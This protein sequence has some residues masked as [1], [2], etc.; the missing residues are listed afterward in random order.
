[1]K[2]YR[3]P[4][5]FTRQIAVKK[6]L[7][8]YAARNEREGRIGSFEYDLKKI[9]R[10]IREQLV[11]EN[12]S[13]PDAKIDARV[14]KCMSTGWE[15]VKER[16]AERK[17]AHDTRKSSGLP[18]TATRIGALEC[19][20]GRVSRFERE[21]LIY[22]VAEFTPEWGREYVHAAFTGDTEAASSG[23]TL[24]LV[25]HSSLHPVLQR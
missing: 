10:H 3:K 16:R 11:K 21:F 4:R 20:M 19:E 12:P 2:N 24:T 13:T 6:T 1:M 5:A 23:A 8:D 25:S 9:V 15:Q 17:R 22:N 18:S 14:A 7:R